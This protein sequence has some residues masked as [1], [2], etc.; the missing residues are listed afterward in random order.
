[1]VQHQS[2]ELRRQVLSK[3][4]ANVDA[5][6][7][8]AGDYAMVY[9]RSSREAGRKQLYG[10]NLECD[11]ESP[12]L[13]ETPIEHEEDVDARRARIGLLRVGLYSRIVAELSTGLCPAAAP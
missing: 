10:Q 9:D 3:L 8:D 6:Q 7:A 11:A 5:G 2:P 13:H 4:K 1:M 12:V